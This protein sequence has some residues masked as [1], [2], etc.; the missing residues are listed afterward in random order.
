[1]EK[2]VGKEVCCVCFRAGLNFNKL[3]TKDGIKVTFLTKLRM[4]ISEV[5]SVV[6]S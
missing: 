1:M 3:T 4:C 5:V 2:S 6:Y